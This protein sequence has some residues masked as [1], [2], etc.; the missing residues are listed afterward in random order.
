MT[1]T[2]VPITFFAFYVFFSLVSCLNLVCK[3]LLGRIVFSCYCKMS[4][5]H[6]VKE[7]AFIMSKIQ[8]V[9]FFVLFLVFFNFILISFPGGRVL[10]WGGGG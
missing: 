8:S 1:V 7:I 5:V 4:I 10:G 3:V 6:L 9:G 2:L